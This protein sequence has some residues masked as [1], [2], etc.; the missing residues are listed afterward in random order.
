M[1]SSDAAVRGLGGVAAAGGWAS[2]GSC[3][4]SRRRRA[5]ESRSPAAGA[6]ASTYRNPRCRRWRCSR[7][8]ILGLATQSLTGSQIGDKAF[9]AAQ[10][11]QAWSVWLCCAM[12]VRIKRVKVSI[13]ATA[14]RSVTSK[15][16]HSDR[17]MD[18]T[19]REFGRMHA[20]SEQTHQRTDHWMSTR[21]AHPASRDSPPALPIFSE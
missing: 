7:P 2:R 3:R 5:P 19:S 8:D 1:T 11:T 14:Q 12:H 4:R 9:C 21:Y 6:A 15:R 16:S 20:S 18:T 10:A 17:L 13:V